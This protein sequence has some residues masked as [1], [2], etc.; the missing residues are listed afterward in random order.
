ML[1]GNFS[2]FYKYLLLKSS[3]VGIVLA[4]FEHQKALHSFRGF[5]FEFQNYEYNSFG[6]SFQKQQFKTLLNG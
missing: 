3:K 6:L 1:G 4:F 5:A 2:F